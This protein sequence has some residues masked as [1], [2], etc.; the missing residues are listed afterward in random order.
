MAGSGEISRGV[1]GAGLNCLISGSD[2]PEVPGHVGCAVV[3]RLI[4]QGNGPVSPVAPVG[5][6][7]T[8]THPFAFITTGIV[9]WSGLRQWPWPARPPPWLHSGGQLSVE[10]RWRGG[11][12][13]FAGDFRVHVAWQ[14]VTTPLPAS[15][16]HQL[17]VYI[18][19]TLAFKSVLSVKRLF[20][21]CQCV[22]V[23]RN[24]KERLNL[25]IGAHFDTS[26]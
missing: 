21:L 14:H 5:Q 17:L 12:A 16:K 24:G 19:F 13:F 23:K 10:W 7:H 4:N 2:W 20:V 15:L 25:N 11:H 3:G 26:C 1:G 8:Q 9:W 22:A 18:T 6:D